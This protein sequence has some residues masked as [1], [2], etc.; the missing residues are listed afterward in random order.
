MPVEQ[1]SLY[2]PPTGLGPVLEIKK[3]VHWTQDGLPSADPLTR[4][5]GR[6][7]QLEGVMKFA[8]SLQSRRAVAVSLGSYWHLRRSATQNSP[9]RN[10][11]R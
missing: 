9:W 2:P 10:R 8:Q 7:G 3:H 11:G 6:L 4:I 5:V 1:K